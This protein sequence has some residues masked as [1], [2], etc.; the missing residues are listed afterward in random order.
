MNIDLIK[1]IIDYIKDWVYEDF[2]TM[3]NFF[4]RIENEDGEYIGDIND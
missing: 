1:K 4:V 3:Q 2:G